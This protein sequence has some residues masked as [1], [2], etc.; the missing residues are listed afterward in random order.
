[1]LLLSQLPLTD[2]D[3]DNSDNDNIAD[4]IA[5][6]WGRICFKPVRDQI[7]CNFSTFSLASC[8]GSLSFLCGRNCFF[9]YYDY[10]FS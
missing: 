4:T 1:M 3:D 9:F 2:V 7:S 10:F 5:T 6:A 8:S